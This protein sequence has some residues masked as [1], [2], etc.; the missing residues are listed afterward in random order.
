VNPITH[1]TIAMGVAVV[2]AATAHADIVSTN[3]PLNHWSYSAIDKLADYGLIDGAMLTIRPITRLEMARHIAQATASLNRMADAPPVLRSIV[4]RLQ[5]E[6]RGELIRLG[7]LDGWY[8][9]SFVKPVEDPYARYL[10]AGEQPDLEN[11]RGDPFKAHSNYRAGF[12]SRAT[13]A[14]TVAFYVHPEFGVASDDWN[15]HL[16]LIEGYGAA[17]TGPV[18]FEMGKDSLWWGPAR[19]GSMIM[20]NNAQPLTMV[21]ITTPQPIELPSILRLAGP[22]KAEWFL[23]ELEKNRDFPYAK[24]S[25][26]RINIKPHPLVELGASRVMMFGGEGQPRVDVRD[27]AKMVFTT[28]ERPE[29]NQLAGIDG[30]IR[31]PL[32]DNPLL[33]SVK[34]YVDAA[35]EDTTGGLPSKWGEIIGMQL[36]DVLRT[37][38]TDVRIEYADDHVG[39]HPGVFYTHGVYTSGYTYKGRVIGHFMGSE[40]HD[41]FVQLSHYLTDNLIADVSFDRITHRLMPERV[42]DIFQC[43]L[44]FF[45]SSEWRIEAGYRYEHGERGD[46]DDN[47]ILQLLL[48]RRF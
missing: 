33:R 24:L 12:A 47:H 38:R 43:D 5:E 10:Y 31:I 26:M 35:G 1:R 20:S 14:D 34:L 45:P 15:E 8:P 30:S 16:T 13:I 11:T 42:A 40:S 27:Y 7:A 25:G 39:G 46:Y 18:E 36:S 6:F 23:A 2:L 41:M 29:T 21:R 22:F 37:G 48:V 28:Y 4:D 3:V 9:S 44:T 17:M 19:H 32:G